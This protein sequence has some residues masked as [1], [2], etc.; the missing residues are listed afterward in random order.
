[1]L[2]VQL[3]Q[4][5]SK[6]FGRLSDFLK[7]EDCPLYISATLNTGALYFPFVVSV[8]YLA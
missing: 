3:G 5:A 8:V 4:D 6:I 1:M 7:I 2:S